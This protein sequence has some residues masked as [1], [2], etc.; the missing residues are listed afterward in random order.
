M[1]LMKKLFLLLSIGF[2]TACL[3]QPEYFSGDPSTLPEGTEIRMEGFL[4]KNQSKTGSEEYSVNGTWLTFDDDFPMDILLNKE[5]TVT[6]K[7]HH[8][9]NCPKMHDPDFPEQCRI[10][11]QLQVRQIEVQ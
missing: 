8:F 5:V 7:V 3:S 11:E 1:K 4:E 6:G 2:L 10:S 9:N